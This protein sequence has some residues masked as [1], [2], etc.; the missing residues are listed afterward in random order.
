MYLEKGD[1]LFDKLLLG[2]LAAVIVVMIIGAGYH[3]KIV[4][5]LEDL[6]IEKD[7]VIQIAGDNLNVSYSLLYNCEENSSKMYNDGYV[8]GI[9]E[10]LDNKVIFNLDNL[11]TS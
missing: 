11:T 3:L 4:D 7:K 10:A 1:V 8:D 5:D 6:N 2:F 9:G